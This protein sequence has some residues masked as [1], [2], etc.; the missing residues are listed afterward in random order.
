VVIPVGRWMTSGCL[1]L[2]V[3]ALAGCERRTISIEA[4][5]FYRVFNPPTAE[6]SCRLYVAIPVPSSLERVPERERVFYLEL[7]PKGEPLAVLRESSLSSSN[8]L[9]LVVSGEIVTVRDGLAYF[10]PEFSPLR[11]RGALCP[12]LMME[13]GRVKH[14]SLE[15][16]SSPDTHET[17]VVSVHLTRVEQGQVLFMK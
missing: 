17:E 10:E 5:V 7:K 1:A 2:L 9:A 13:E 4:I 3:I 6:G 8:E 11:L 16:A 14:L 15:L 12:E